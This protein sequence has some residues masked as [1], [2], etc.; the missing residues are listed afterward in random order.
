MNSARSSAAASSALTDLPLPKRALLRSRADFHVLKS[1]RAGDSERSIVGA[2]AAARI[3]KRALDPQCSNEFLNESDFPNS[4]RSGI[5]THGNPP[6]TST[7]RIARIRY[8]SRPLDR[9]FC[10][11]K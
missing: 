11:R 3:D 9:E 1:G 2:P 10:R 7:A 8:A 4:L 6:A 5:P